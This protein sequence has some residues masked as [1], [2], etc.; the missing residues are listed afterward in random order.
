MVK[1]NIIVQNLNITYY[2][3][4]TFTP[5]GA[6]VFLHGWES[7]ALHLK[8]IFENFDNYIAIDLPGFGLSEKP[9]TAW[10]ATE[11]ASFFSEF[12]K[13]LYISNPTLI[14]HS[15]GGSIIVKYLSTGGEAK[16]IFLIDASGV[17]I[18]TARNKLLLITAKVS[19][20]FTWVIPPKLFK[21]IRKS[22]YNYINSTD[23]IEAN[24][25]KE[26]YLKIITE[27]LRPDMAKIA[28]STV[29]IWGVDD[30]DVPLEYAK[31]MKNLIS[32]SKLLEIPEAGHFPFIDQPQRFM[33]I[34]R[35]EIDAD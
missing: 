35:K 12:I 2:Q 21:K 23:Y 24:S 25:L 31:I 10:A 8:T 6:L 1:K 15:F 19:K 33:E 9:G 27:D 26:S 3:S 28:T 18:K 32:G 20:L 16:K 4:S 5:V 13:K 29:M 30:K 17:R 34:F 22:F 7:Q 14:G 11:Y